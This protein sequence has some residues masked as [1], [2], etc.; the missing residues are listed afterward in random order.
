VYERSTSQ[1]RKGAE[2][3]T[4]TTIERATL[5]GSLQTVERSMSV[6]RPTSS[7]SQVDSTV[8]RKDVSGN[9]SPFAQDVKRISK[10]GPEETTDAAH[11]EAGPDGKLALA[12]REIDHIQ[13]NPDG[14][15]VEESDLYS[16]YSAGR[17]GD[18]NAAEPRLQQQIQRQRKPGPGGVVV[19]TTSVRARLPNDP[20]RFGAYEK[21]SQTISTRTDASG[22]EVKNTSTEVGRRNPNGEIVVEQGRVDE[23]VSTKK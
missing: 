15:Q 18:A 16:K 14:S 12:S 11:Y 21:V 6:E 1:I 23:T 2:T 4:S 8:Y 22:R 3:E 13:T 19:E 9:F 5:N 20:S 7:G 10:S 17:T